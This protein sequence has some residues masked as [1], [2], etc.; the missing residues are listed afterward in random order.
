MDLDFCMEFV[1]AGVPA[2]SKDQVSTIFKA[3]ELDPL[4]S[5]IHVCGIMD[6]LNRTEQNGDGPSSISQAF[7]AGIIFCSQS[8]N[9]EV[10]NML[11]LSDKLTS[12]H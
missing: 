10:Q 3:A 11:T 1:K 7:I 9:P 8:G 2:T 5:I 6:K 4:G 12:L